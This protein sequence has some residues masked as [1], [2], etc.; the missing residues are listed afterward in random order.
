M[1][2][3]MK[4]SMPEDCVSLTSQWFIKPGMEERVLETIP[5]LVA[6]VHMHEPETLMYL[7][8]TPWAKPDAGH[9]LQSLPPSGAPCLLFV[10]QYASQAAFLKH[11]HGK[12]FCDY[13]AEHGELFISAHGKPYTTVTFLERR[14]GFIRGLNEPGVKARNHH[15]AVMFEIMALNQDNAKAFY[16]SVFGWHYQTGSQGFAYVHFPATM[17]PLLGGIGQSQAHVP[18]LEAGHSFY[19][20]V[21]SL[22]EAIARAEQAGGK[23]YLQPTSVDG[24]RFAMIQDP[25]GN[26]VGLVEPFSP[27]T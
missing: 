7:V 19:I 2:A 13:V 24:Y 25:E 21:D 11:L 5:H 14:N 10:E 17:P 27:S 20:L 16:S 23:Q 1:T 12:P 26:P 22:E 3:L 15:P 9:V 8:H 18:G 6:Q 4:Q